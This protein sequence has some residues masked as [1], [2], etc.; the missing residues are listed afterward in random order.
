V[1]RDLDGLAATEFDVL[2]VGAGIYG[3][4]VAWDAAQRGLT[5]ALVERDD[6][7][8]GTS[9]NNAKTLHGGVRSLQSGR[10][11]EL[12]EYVRERRALMR[13]APHLVRPLPFLVPTSR[14]LTRNAL[15]FR[16]YFTA[17]DLLAADRNRGL[18][19][20]RHLPPSRLLSREECLRLDPVADPAEVTGGVLWHDGQMSSGERMTLAFVKSAVRA[21]AVAVNHARVTRWLLDGNRVIGAHV[22]DEISQGELD[23]RARLTI[24]ASGPAALS[25]L[26][27]LFG[28]TATPLVPALSLAMNLVTRRVVSDAAVGGFAR[29]RLFFLAP[30][31]DVTIA[32]TSHDPFT[33]EAHTLRV[34]EADIARLLA[35]LNAAFPRAG[36][37]RDDVRLVHRGL[38]PAASIDGPD[39]RLLK[40][41][42]VRDHA[43]DGRPGLVSVVGVRY[44][45]AR[46]TA[47]QATDL[48][49]ERLGR[50]V[51]SC[52]THETPLVGGEMS[53]V[54]TYVRTAEA[55]AVP[56]WT[57][58]TSRHLALRYGDESR[59]V[60]ALAASDNS[61]AEPLASTTATLGA[62]IVYAARDEMAVTLADAVLRRTD[63]GSAGHPGRAALAR[64]AAVMAP[65]HGWTPAHVEREI[66]AVERAY[67]GTTPA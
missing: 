19:P 11:G 27:P 57:A 41:S 15:A 30:W 20:A 28:G 45:T 46:Y 34:S 55:A 60:Q 22:R 50:S 2:V 42:V 33:G 3:S 58:A 8:A 63:L 1:R 61:L 7:G 64:A 54:D 65:L 47:A 18:D 32:G 12:R 4:A 31:R 29:G 9:F 48:A 6:F 44:T 43:E 51:P 62:E 53:D 23:V 66:Q 14:S 59:E 49:A 52:R 13:I 25:L 17:Y 38:L 21:G 24:N 5:V 36:L 16:T 26:T 56:P 10:L 35:D 67:E 37:R 40:S 39:V